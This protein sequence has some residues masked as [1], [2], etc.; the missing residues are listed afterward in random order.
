MQFPFFPDRTIA[1]LAKAINDG[2]TNST[3]GPLFLEAG[4]D[5]WYGVGVSKLDKAARALR[6]M[7][8]DDGSDPA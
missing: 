1:V 2:E 6:A 3:M 7:H 5:P 4:A 8:R